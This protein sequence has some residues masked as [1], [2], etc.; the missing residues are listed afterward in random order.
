MRVAEHWFS[1]G[2]KIGGSSCDVLKNV[3]AGLSLSLSFLLP[4][5]I[6]IILFLILFVY[7]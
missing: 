4:S 5:V 7:C 6:T 3:C 1:G 2:I